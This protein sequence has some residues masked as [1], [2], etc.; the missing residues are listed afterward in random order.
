MY[1]TPEEVC[2]RLKVCLSTFYNLVRRGK[3]PLYKFDGSVRVKLADLEAYEEAS[4]QPVKVSTQ[5]IQP[6]AVPR[7]GRPR[8]GAVVE[9][10]KLPPRKKTA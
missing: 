1:L 2:A 7:R 8:L 10:P 5:D 4:I 3:F 9:F 6:P